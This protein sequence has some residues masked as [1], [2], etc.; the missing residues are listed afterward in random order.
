MTILF[1]VDGGRGYRGVAGMMLRETRH[2]SNC[3]SNQM[4]LHLHFKVRKQDKI[5]FEKSE[6]DGNDFGGVEH[7]THAG[8]E[9]AGY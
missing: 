3:N 1:G 8:P 7:S 5:F 2:N 4:T 6:D 9:P